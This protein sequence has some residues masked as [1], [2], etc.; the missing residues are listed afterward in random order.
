MNDTLLYLFYKLIYLIGYLEIMMNKIF[1]NRIESNNDFQRVLLISIKENLSEYVYE[2]DDDICMNYDFGIVERTI[3]T[4]KCHFL[5]EELDTDDIDN[6]FEAPIGSQFFTIEVQYQNKSY[7][8]DVKDINYSFVNNKIFFSDHVIYLMRKNY[9]I[10]VEEYSLMIIDNN[11]DMITLNE[12][13]YI[14]LCEHGY[15][16]LNKPVQ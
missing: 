12:N 1:N 6:M 2:I 5:F 16:I 11:C 8:L 3:G 7:S 13:Q 9:D 10:L 15:D 14:Q 4:K